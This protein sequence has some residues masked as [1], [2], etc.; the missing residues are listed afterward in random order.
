MRCVACVKRYVRAGDGRS[1]VR[2]MKKGSHF[3]I[4]PKSLRNRLGR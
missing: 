4:A 2:G 1:G 3:G